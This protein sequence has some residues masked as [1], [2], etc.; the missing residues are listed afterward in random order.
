MLQNLAHM[1]AGVY[2]SDDDFVKRV[3]AGAT[4]RKEDINIPKLQRRALPP[5]LDKIA[6]TYAERNQAIVA[7]H[8]TGAY[9]YQQ[10]GD[11]FGV[12]L[13]TVGK[14]VRKARKSEVGAN[15]QGMAKI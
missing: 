1:N 2:L 14:I 4:Q 3:Q 5:P 13:T 8:A 15:W 6:S 10:I 12:H 7:A 9:S 11:F